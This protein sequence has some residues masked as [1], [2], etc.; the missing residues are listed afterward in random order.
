MKLNHKIIKSLFAFAAGIMLF[1][2]TDES[3]VESGYGSFDSE[4]GETIALTLSL[5][6]L[7]RADESEPKSECEK[8]ED[9]IDPNKIILLFFYADEDIN[10]NTLIR[11]YGPSELSKI[12][13]ETTSTGELQ[14]WYV[15]LPILDE[16]DGFADVLRN[17]DFKVAALVNWTNAKIPDLK[18]AVI[19]NG[20]IVASGSHIEVLHHLE[21]DDT[22][23]NDAYSFLMESTGKMG[24][25]EAWV[26][27]YFSSQ[28][29]AE[30][31]IR[32]EW[33][34]GGKYYPDNSTRENYY[35]DLRLVWNFN[36]TIMRPGYGTVDGNDTYDPSK[37]YEGGFKEQW[38]YKNFEELNAWFSKSDWI[39]KSRLESLEKI[40]TDNG[41]FEFVASDEDDTYAYRDMSDN[42]WG[43]VLHGGGNYN[44]NAFRFNLLASGSIYVKW[45]RINGSEGKIKIQGRNHYGDE[46]F[47]KDFTLE[48][49]EYGPQTYPMVLKDGKWEKAEIGVTGD[50]E[51]IS[52]FAEGGDVIIH[53]I[54]YIQDEYLYN[55]CRD[56]VPV[57]KDH[58]I[59]MYG[60]QQYTKLGNYWKKGMLFNLSDFNNLSLVESQ[61]PGY[62][63]IQLMRSVAKVE[64]RLP[65]SFNAHNV[66]LRC[67]N[68]RAR[69][70]P[71]DL[72]TSTSNIWLDKVGVNGDGLKYEFENIHKAMIAEKIH[73]FLYKGTDNYQERLAWY[74]GSWA[75]GGN[76]FGVPVPEEDEEYPFPRIINPRIERSDFV[77]FIKVGDAEGIYTKYVLYVPEKFIDDPNTKGRLGDKP[78]VCHIEFRRGEG[79]NGMAA[80]PSI[81]VDDDYCYRIYFTKNG[82][83]S[84]G[85]KNQYP[86]FKKEVLKDAEGNDLKDENGNLQYGDYIT[87]ENH[88]ENDVDNLRNHWP[89]IRNHI[90]SFVV[91]DANQKVIVMKLEVLPWK[92]TPEDYNNYIW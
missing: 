90:Y 75:T 76:V 3:L 61:Y 91:E 19:E 87:W 17:H 63:K 77:R 38:L 18:D 64:L 9:Y 46:E 73:P 57:S 41:N 81:N 47:Q 67:S 1:S 92:K 6:S 34:P 74:Y 53:E 60:I 39:T 2:C 43:V 16:N 56:G 22:Y 68:R 35:E 32:D 7:T 27:N 12:P 65:N 36:G 26:K 40:T 62:Q 14:N 28:A 20:E 8:Y 66:Y 24:L 50:S 51:Y 89:I 78:K 79:M 29:E 69:V 80:D 84:N 31:F 88:Y 49:D 59:Q 54:E 83:Y 33:F 42:K 10:Y 44:K 85:G 71:V 45:E 55:T 48:Y 11:Q 13:I 37:D 5:Q 25:T 52:I 72:S 30:K 4:E 58:P 82:F 23:K 86:S 70:E 15:K 21:E